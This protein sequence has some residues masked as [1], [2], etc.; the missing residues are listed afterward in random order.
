MTLKYPLPD[1]FLK[2]ETRNGYTIPVQMKQAWAVQLDLLQELM[3]ICR[4]H[5]IQMFVAEGTLLG[6]IRHHGFIPWDDD[7]DVVLLRNDYDR[8]MQLSSEFRAPYFLQSIHTDLGY[9]NR[10]AQLRMDDTLALGRGEKRG[11]RCHQGIFID[12]FVMDAMPNSPRKFKHHYA[13]ISSA[14]LRL[15]IISKLM[16]RLPLGLYRWCREHTKCLSDKVRYTRY[17]DVMRSVPTSNRTLSGAMICQNMSLT[18]FP[19]SAYD[20]IVEMPFEHITVPVPAGYDQLLRI[21]YG[22]YMTPVQAPS[23]HGQMTFEIPDI[24]L[25]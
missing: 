15:K 10:H 20:S 16:E 13:H 24:S 11:R 23:L 7:I 22:D 2:E 3:R 25:S 9:R 6:T 21:E 4:E 8:L 18:V 17:E 19:L 5:N 12:I 14:K 1:G